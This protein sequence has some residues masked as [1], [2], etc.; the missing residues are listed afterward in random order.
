MPEEVKLKKLMTI[1]DEVR[2]FIRRPGCPDCMEK[3]QGRE[4]IY[5]QESSGQVLIGPQEQPMTVWSCEHCD[6]SINL[7]PGAF[8]QPGFQ[9]IRLEGPP[10][11]EPDPDQN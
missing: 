8:P 6:Y 4:R 3:N 2:H 7:P 5:L 10:R 9:V 11:P 1:E